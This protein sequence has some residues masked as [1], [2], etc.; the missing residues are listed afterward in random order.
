VKT[1][2]GSQLRYYQGVKTKPSLYSLIRKPQVVGVC[3]SLS[4]GERSTLRQ[5]QGWGF[6]Q[7]FF[8]SR[9]SV[10]VCVSVR[11]RVSSVLAPMPA[12]M[13]APPRQLPRPRKCSCQCPL[14]RSRQCPHTPIVICDPTNL[15]F[16]LSPCLCPSQQAL[17]STLI[18]VR[19]GALVGAPS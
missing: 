17:L 18:S 12:S 2:Q 3:R 13:P 10:R 7:V 8:T 16:H 19:V 5:F 6:L 11:V 15:R 9:V 4:W 1:I 14:L